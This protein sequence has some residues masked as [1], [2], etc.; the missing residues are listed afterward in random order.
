MTIYLDIVLIENLIINYILLMSTGIISK[1][2]LNYL[3]LL[4]SSTVGSIYSVIDY[5]ANIDMF[6]SFFI[7][8]IISYIMIIIS[9][10]KIKLKKAIKV[11]M[12]LCYYF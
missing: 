11:L 9:F 8:I 2:K 10:P 12:H 1:T 5:V 6:F 7:K 4:I 3:S